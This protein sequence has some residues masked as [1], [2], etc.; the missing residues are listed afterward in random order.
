MK[1]VLASIIWIVLLNAVFTAIYAIFMVN[2]NPTIT[3]GES[4]EF[5]QNYGAYF[6]LLSVT[7]IVYL[8]AKNKLPGARKR[9]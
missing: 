2:F 3:H 8:A 1:K 6:F 7:C 5:G 9:H 4:Y